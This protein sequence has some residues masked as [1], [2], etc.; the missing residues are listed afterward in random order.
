MFEVAIAL[1]AATVGDDAGQ[2]LNMLFGNTSLQ[3]DVV[4]ARRRIPARAGAFLRRARAT[5]R[6]GCGGGW[7]RRRGP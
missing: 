5:G 1:A 7:R 2:L 6:M 4:L 3:E